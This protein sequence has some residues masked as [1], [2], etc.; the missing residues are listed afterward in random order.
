ML[1]YQSPSFCGFRHFA[2][3]WST[4]PHLKHFRG[5]RSEFLFDEA[6]AEQAFSLSFLIFLK[7]FSTEWL[8]NP[9]NEHF[10]LAEFALSLFL[11]DPNWLLSRFKYSVCIEE[12]YP[13]QKC[14][15]I[16][17]IQTEYLN[18]DSSQSSQGKHNEKENSA[19]VKCTFCGLTN[20]SVEKCFKKIRKDKEKALSTGASSNKNFGS[21][22]SEM[23]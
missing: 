12:M 15:N 18:L 20:H 8:V 5:R 13:D 2:I 22:A 23:F 7:H 4:E 1:C 11:L 3:R 10:A 16:S 21:S 17:S 19:K 14:L 9:Q 6:P